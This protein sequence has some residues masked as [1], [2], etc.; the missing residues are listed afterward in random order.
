MKNQRQEGQDDPCSRLWLLG[1]NH[2]NNLG[3]FKILVTTNLCDS[4]VTHGGGKSAVIFQTSPNNHTILLSHPYQVK[5]SFY[6]IR[7]RALDYSGNTQLS[8]FEYPHRFNFQRGLNHCKKTKQNTLT[9]NKSQ[10]NLQTPGR[11]PL[12]GFALG[13]DLLKTPCSGERLSI[14]WNSRPGFLSELA[15]LTGNEFI[16]A[17]ARSESALASMQTLTRHKSAVAP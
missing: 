6:M 9:L 12:L 5:H 14:T 1:K 7:G 2:F 8:H 4:R 16:V 15:V 13:M 3:L 10:V 11:V 17:L